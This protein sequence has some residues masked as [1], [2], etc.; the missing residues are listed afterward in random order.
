MTAAEHA[1]EAERLLAQV[2]EH[3]EKRGRKFGT[4]QA[5]LVQYATAHAT[6]AL[7]EQEKAGR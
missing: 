4:D 6:L 1:A 7:Y 3:L 5:H 2:A